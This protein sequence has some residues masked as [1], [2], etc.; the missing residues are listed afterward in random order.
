MA[1][2]RRARVYR[3]VHDLSQEQDRSSGVL[4]KELS[5]LV[6]QK[7]E[8]IRTRLRSGEDARQRRLP[9]ADE[10]TEY[11]LSKRLFRGEV[12]QE[13]GLTHADLIRIPCSEVPS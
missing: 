8:A 1:S 9:A 10:I 6:E 12:V 5:D 11:R 3:A 4:L 7:R 2:A 13:A